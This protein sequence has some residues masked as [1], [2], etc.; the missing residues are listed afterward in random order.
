MGDASLGN[1]W[2]C[3]DWRGA[4]AR[5]FDMQR[6]VA[7]AFT[8]RDDAGRIRAQK[9]LVCSLDAKMLAVKHVADNTAASGVDGVRWLTSAEKMNAARSLTSKGYEAKPARLFIVHQ[10]GA[11]KERHI[12]VPTVYDRAMQVLY[13]MSLDP[14]A[15]TLGDKKSFAFRKGRSHLD[16]H[17]YIVKALSGGDPPRFGVKADVEAYYS[18]IS[19]SWLI[20]NIPM[21]TKVLRQ[22]LTA[23]YVFNGELFPPDDTGIPLGANISTML[24]NLALDGLQAHIFTALNGENRGVTDYADGN[25]VRY[26]DDLFITARTYESAR[27]I[28]EAVRAFLTPRGLR[29][30]DGKSRIITPEDSFDFL[31]RTYRRIDGAVSAGPSDAAVK[32]LEES[33]SE[34]I[35][36]WRGSQK[37][38]IEKINRRLTGWAT[39]HKAADAHDAFRHM[40]VYVKALLMQLCEKL[41]PR[42][43]RAKLIDRYFYLRH[44]GEHIYALRGKP[45]IRVAKLSETV[46]ADHRCARV[47]HNPYLDEP[48]R[49]TWKDERAAENVTGKYKAIWERQEGRCHYCGKP[50]L[51]DQ[52]KAV[53]IIDASKAESVK[54]LA[55]IHKRCETSEIAYIRTDGPLYGAADIYEL[56]EKMTQANRNKKGLKFDG[57]ATHFRERADASFALTFD[58]IGKIIGA[59]LCAS[60]FRYREYWH[61]RGTGKISECWLANGY[62]IRGL[63]LERR[64]VQFARDEKYGLPVNIPDVFLSGRVPPNAKAELENHFAYVRKKYAI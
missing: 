56:L 45:D 49:E 5:V 3:A 21:D 18:S 29:L 13:A 9:D 44:D 47:S 28:L 46:P 60:A 33:M 6:R 57:L 8:R 52:R 17:A 26:A 35:L 22:F 40:D 7:L 24:G 64:R 54:N 14:A 38:L 55:Y 41:N 31:S 25:L 50:I 37:E 36:P 63:D 59:P 15:E 58:E 39:Y 19:H 42:T 1:L 62:A 2:D 20:A 34:L 32:K 12:Q 30:N 61:R 48:Y 27:R 10:K 53:A 16:A 23:G 43:P 11:R 51:A 4:E